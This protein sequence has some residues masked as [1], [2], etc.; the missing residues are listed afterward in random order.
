MFNSFDILENKF[1]ILKIH[2]D[3][4]PYPLSD[5]KFIDFYAVGIVIISEHSIFQEMN[6]ED[7]CV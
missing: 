1:E 2:F 7:R 3:S 5:I 6:E 4:I